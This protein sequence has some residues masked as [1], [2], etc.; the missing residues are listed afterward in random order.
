[1]AD[2]SI[3]ICEQDGSLLPNAPT[4]KYILFLSTDGGWKKKDDAG[5]ITPTYDI[6]VDVK[7]K[8][9]AADTTV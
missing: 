9:S 3:Q 7:V 4:G 1:M 8:V 5:V 6:D 2:S